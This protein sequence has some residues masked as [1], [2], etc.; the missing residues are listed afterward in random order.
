MALYS[1]PAIEAIIRQGLQ[2]DTQ[3]S[4]DAY[5]I[6]GTASSSI[7]PAGLLNSVVPITAASTGTAL[8]KMVAD[9]KAL[10]QAMVAT[11]GGQ[12]PVILLNP[13][14]AFA[15]GFAQTTTG[16]FLF[17]SVVEAGQKF[18]CSFIVSQNVPVGTVVAVDAYEFATATG[19]T[20]RLAISN[21]ATL[22][23]EDTAP[24]AIG[25]PGAPATVAAPVRSL[26]QTDSIA[27]RLTLYVSWVMRRPGMVQW[28]ATVGW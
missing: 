11:G 3:Q 15:L 10:V 14:Q 18:N 23:E 6:D 2:D 12:D 21:E 13:A 4:L 22:H 9:L 27:I 19:D 26:F 1:N 28:I 17:A 8:E 5:L 16:E 7:R 20:P 24:L 25:T